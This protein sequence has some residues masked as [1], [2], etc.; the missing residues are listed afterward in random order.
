MLRHL[1]TLPVALPVALSCALLAA[2]CSSTNSTNRKA[3]TLFVTGRVTVESYT[4]RGAEGAR[5]LLVSADLNS[6]AT[7]RLTEF[8]VTLFEDVDNDGRIGAGEQRS[9]WHAT[10]TMGTS[11][12]VAT[13]NDFLGAKQTAAAS[14]QLKLEVRVVYISAGGVIEEESAL[15]PMDL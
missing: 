12:L 7:S 1:L 6:E 8:S 4:S 14:T 9:R 11:R 2:S 5:M 10:S 15:V 13:G 3:D